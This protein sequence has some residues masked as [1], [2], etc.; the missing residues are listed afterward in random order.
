MAG[1]NVGEQG[2]VES[3]DCLQRILWAARE[4]M[5]DPLNRDLA[6]SAGIDVGLFAS[7]TQRVRLDPLR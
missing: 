6:P 1:A 4:M 7:T 5:N 2:Q 3:A